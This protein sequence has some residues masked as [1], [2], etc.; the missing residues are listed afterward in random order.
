MNSDS[1]VAADAT[2]TW[3]IYDAFT[4]NSVN[5][6]ALK[7]MLHLFGCLEEDTHKLCV[8]ANVEF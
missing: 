2:Q 7:E 3:K 4:C 6:E 8:D 5:E 1:D